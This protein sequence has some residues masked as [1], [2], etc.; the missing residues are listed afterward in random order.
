MKNDFA[1]YRL[2]KFVTIPSWLLSPVR[3]RKTVLPKRDSP[4]LRRW[5]ANS[6]NQVSQITVKSANSGQS[7]HAII[8]LKVGGTSARDGTLRIAS[9][10][11]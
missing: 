3:S 9:E 5:I 1:K 8:T 2:E 11:V 6:K 7:R 4:E 10:Y